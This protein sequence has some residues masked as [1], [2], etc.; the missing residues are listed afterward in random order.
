[1]KLLRKLLILSHRY[2]GIVLSLMAIMWFATGFVMM[3]AGGMPRLSQEMLRERRPHLDLSRVRMGPAAALERLGEGSADAPYTGRVRLLTVMDRPAYRIGGDTVFADTGDT[4]EPV[5][6]EQSRTVA[7][8]FMRV[9]EERVRHL[10]TLDRVDQWTLAQNI[11]GPL[12]KFAVDDGA[13]TEVYVQPRTAEVA[14]LTTTRSRALAWIGTIPHW[15]YFAALRANQPLWFRIVVWTSGAVCVL[16]V[17]GLALGVTQFRRTRPFRLSAAIPYSGWM[18][19][20]YITG[21]VF[22]VFTL[23]WAFSGLLSMEPF[24]WTNARGIEVSRDAFTGGAADFKTFTATDTVTWNRVLDGRAIEEMEFTRIQDRHYY[25]VRQAPPAE[26]PERR[27]ERLHQP[28]PIVGRQEPDRLLV[29][30]ETLTIRHEPFTAESL[31]SRLEVDL[32]SAPIVESAMLTDYDSYYYSRG[33]QTPLPVLRVKFGDPAQ[34]WVYVDPEMSQVLAEIPRLARVERWLYNGLHS[35]DF[36]FWYNKRPLWDVGMIVL[37]AGGLATS[38]IGL[39]MGIRRLRRGARK[40]TRWAADARA[41]EPNAAL[42]EPIRQ[43]SP[44]R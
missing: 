40:M 19:W 43:S 29:D 17:L 18:R 37:L 2:L 25:V 3:Y 8:Q 5:S 27:R 30:A 13:G 14:N 1:M 23:T 42:G 31:L 26:T 41:P 11:R 20:H 33:G 24:E 22:G 10:A 9:P 38:T 21:V 28:Y 36:A 16:A 44:P 12:H 7:S 6:L 32:P 15:L 35:L 34:T 4:L 39:I